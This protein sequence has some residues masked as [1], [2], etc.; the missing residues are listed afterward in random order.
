MSVLVFL[1][2]APG[3]A[4]AQVGHSPESSPFRDIPKGHTITAAGG[5]LSG[6]GGRFGIGPHNGAVFGVRYD[7]RS[8]SAL[9]L[10]LGIGRG[11]L[12]RFV[13]DPFVALANRRTGP[14]K[15][16]VTF[17]E[18]IIQ[19]NVT[20]GKTWR[21]LAPFVAASGGIAFGADTPT[22]TSGFEFGRKVY[23]AP[24]AGIRVFFTDRIHLRAEARATF[25][26]LNYPTTFQREPAG[27]PGAPP[28]I[29]GDNLTE[30]TTSS[31]LQA[32][33]GFSFSP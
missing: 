30:W 4:L 5:Y 21:R 16:G 6:E 3:A 14:V 15:Q 19:L 33:L 25:W 17:A 13:V 8:A 20:G 11:N 28:V 12:E 31:W 23:L 29:T 9:Q 18:L 1:A 32:G 22:D 2:Q 26:K 27:Q 7:I 24:S 10:G